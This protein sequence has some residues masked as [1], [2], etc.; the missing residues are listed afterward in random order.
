M[1]GG[2]FD[3]KCFDVMNFA[4]MVDMEIKS[5]LDM[6]KDVKETFETANAMV[7][8]AGDIAKEF[9]WFFS[10]DTGEENVKDFLEQKLAEMNFILNNRVIPKT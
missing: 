5:D 1:S 2:R 7:T 8:L 4:G 6:P 3:Y 10:G 9:E